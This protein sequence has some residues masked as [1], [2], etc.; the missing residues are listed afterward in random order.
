MIVLVKLYLRYVFLYCVASLRHLAFLH[1]TSLSGLPSVK[2]SV[3]AHH[4]SFDGTA[5][6]LIIQELI[7]VITPCISV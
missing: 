3:T 2:H 7:Y 6:Q 5:V 4:A 1:I